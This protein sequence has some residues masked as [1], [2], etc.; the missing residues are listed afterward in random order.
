MK[1]KAFI[2]LLAAS[3]ILMSFTAYKVSEEKQL[4]VKYNVTDWQNKLNVIDYTIQVLK[5]SDVPA[6]IALPLTDSLTKMQA[7]LVS[8]LRP[9]LQPAADTTTSKTKKK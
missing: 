3:V 4:T 8:Q 9:Q 1:K 6:K 2:M 5:T 7:D